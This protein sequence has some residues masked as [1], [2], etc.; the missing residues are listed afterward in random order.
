MV[1]IIN[2]RAKP[3]LWFMLLLCFVDIIGDKF[4]QHSDHYQK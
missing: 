2:Y 1:V 4:A 3:V